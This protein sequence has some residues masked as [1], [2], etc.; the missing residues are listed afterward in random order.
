MFARIH[1]IITDIQRS[2]LAVRKRWF[3][4]MSAGT[5]LIVVGLWVQ[6]LRATPPPDNAQA[7]T[8]P[9]HTLGAVLHAGVLVLKDRGEAL[10]DRIRARIGAS[11]EI[12]IENPDRTFTVET[13]TP[14]PAHPLP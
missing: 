1:H 8:S 13:L 3:Y 7:E 12:T 14:I 11:R 6:Y 5:M 10:A 9:R 2:E 4:V